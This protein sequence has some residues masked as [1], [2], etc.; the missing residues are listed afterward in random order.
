MSLAAILYYA[1]SA[2]AVLIVLTIH[3]YS[4]AYAAYK[5]GDPTAKNVGRLTHN[6]IKHIDPFGALCMLL[7]HFGWAK[8]VPINARNFKNPKRGFAIS[9]LAGPLANLITAFISAFVYLLTYALL[10][11]VSFGSEFTFNIAQNTLDFIYV[12]HII[13]VGIAVF[14]LLPVPPLDGSRILMAILP[15]KAYF[16][17]MKYERRIYLVLIAWLLL[18]GYVSAFLLS[19]P[20]ISNNAPLSFIASLFD[21]S[22]RLSDIFTWISK[23]MMAFWKLIPFLR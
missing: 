6:P 1:L 19:N 12:F 11:E 10:R 18:G 15:P 16:G 9:A 17:I 21:L 22:G 4:H 23:G 5:L 14:N 7:F 13:N 8:P 3:E 20:I 2:L